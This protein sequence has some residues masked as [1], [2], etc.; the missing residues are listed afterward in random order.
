MNAWGKARF[1]V[2]DEITHGRGPAWAEKHE[3]PSFANPG[4]GRKM[5]VYLVDP[6]PQYDPKV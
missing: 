1:I 6:G 4:I 5:N 2:N 3:G